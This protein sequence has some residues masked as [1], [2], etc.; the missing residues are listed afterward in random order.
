MLRLATLSDI[1]ALIIML[2][3][4]QLEAGCYGN[5]TPCDVSLDKSLRFFMLSGRSAVI[6]GEVDGEL[7]AMT[8]IMLS[9]SWFNENQTVAREL[10]WYIKPAFRNIGRLAI[11]M[12][13]WLEKW[14]VDVRANELA[15]ARTST[16]SPE[17]LDK[18]YRKK[19][20][21]PADSYYTKGLKNG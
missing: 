18:F 2:K 4:F 21:S 15:M 16:L 20:F 1:P 9:P 7:I 6:V 8:G 12:F 3:D 19:G 10:F 11:Q 14:A 13:N 17:K 5:I